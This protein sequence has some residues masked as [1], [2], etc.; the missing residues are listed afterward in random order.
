MKNF[1]STILLAWFRVLAK[2]QLLKNKPQVIG[3]TGSAGKTTTMHA[4]AAVLQDS[5]KIKVSN[6]ANSQ[7]GLS[8]NIL[9]LDPKSFSLFDWLRLSFLAPFK[10][11]TNWEK[12]DIYIAEM[13]IDSP[14]EPANMEYLLKIVK[15][16]IGIFTSVT[17]VHAQ[18]FDHLVTERDVKKRAAAL[19]EAIASEKAKL[20]TRL[21]ST[22]TAIFNGDDAIITAAASSTLATKCSFGHGKTTTVRMM[23]TDWKSRQTTFTLKHGAQTAVISLQYLLPEHYGY[24]FAAAIGAGGALGVDLPTAAKAIEKNFVL[25]PGRASLIPGVN[26]STIL[27]GSYNS[28]P[29]PLVDFLELVEE[30]KQK[31]TD[32]NAFPKRLVGLL[33]DMRELGKLSGYEHTQVAKKSAEILDAI[34]LVGPQMREHALAVIQKSKKPVFWFASASEAGAQLAKDLQKDDLLL[35]KGS[36]NTILLEIAIEK[37]MAEPGRAEELLCRRG[38]FWDRERTTLKAAV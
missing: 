19:L 1:F 34:Y 25:P 4:V 14:D 9:G 24:S 12:Y 11:L 8:L 17:L 20:L 7:S 22:G 10:L 13:G 18:A 21:P 5:H 27:D 31:K 33:G 23:S 26:G 6:K 35:V 3:I 36:Q 29:A 15:P 32:K 38:K 37:L 16:T 30:I 28:A 2:L